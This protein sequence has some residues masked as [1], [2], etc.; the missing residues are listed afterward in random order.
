MLLDDVWALLEEKVFPT[1]SS[2]LLFNQYT[3]NELA[4]DLPNGDHIRRKNLLGYLRS[5]YERP[6][7]LVVGEAPGWRGCR[8]SGVPF[9]S[10]SQLS[11]DALPFDG[12]QSSLRTS[13]YEESTATIFW[14]QLLPYHP[15]FIAWNALPYHP[16]KQGNSLSNRTPNQQEIS[17]YADL[18]SALVQLLKPNQ[19]IAVGRS[20]EHAMGIM[21]MPAIYIRHPAHGGASSFRTGIQHLFESE[22]FLAA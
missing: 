18:L 14:R 17:A 19:I 13:P 9:T 7:I 21:Q 4:T 6:S 11:R 12:Q 2:S 15:R 16:H 22:L 8:F 3:N 1:P 20:A 5:F 10:E